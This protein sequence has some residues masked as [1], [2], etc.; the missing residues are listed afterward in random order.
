M[1]EN[2]FEEYVEFLK[3]LHYIEILETDFRMQTIALNIRGGEFVVRA[4]KD[5]LMDFSTALMLIDAQGI[6][7]VN[8][9][10]FRKILNSIDKDT[11]FY[12]AFM[13]QGQK[14]S[15]KSLDIFLKASYYTQTYKII[16]TEFFKELE[17]E[18]SV[19]NPRM[20]ESNL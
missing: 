12:T 7:D 5:D 20:N 19:I 8:Y 4:Q 16:N 3:N 18:L 15:K 10:Y 9:D 13:L 2:T 11:S 6:E 17:K 14:L 1:K